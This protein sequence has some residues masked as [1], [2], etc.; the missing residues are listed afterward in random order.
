MASTSTQRRTVPEPEPERIEKPATERP[1]PRQPEIK[2]PKFS[3][4]IMHSIPT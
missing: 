2:A 3:I 4:K 1:A